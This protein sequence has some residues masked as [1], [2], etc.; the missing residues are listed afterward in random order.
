M[1]LIL[2]PY[3]EK[4]GNRQR[5]NGW[6]KSDDYDG[7]DDGKR[8]SVATQTD[9]DGTYRISHYQSR[10]QQSWSQWLSRKF[11]F[12]SERLYGTKSL[13]TDQEP[14]R[15]SPAPGIVYKQRNKVRN[16]VI[17]G[18]HGW[19]PQTRIVQTIFGELLGTSE[20]LC[21]GMM[22]SLHGMDLAKD[23]N[24]TEVALSTHG[25]SVRERVSMSLEQILNDDSYV[26]A[27]GKADKI[28]IAGHSQ[29]A[30]VSLLLL[31]ELARRRII[32]LRL[33]DCVL[34]SLAGILHGPYTTLR[35]NLVV[36]YVETEAARELFQF[37]ETS[38]VTR[39]SIEQCTHN[40][41]PV[42]DIHL[43][44][45]S[46][47]CWLLE[48]GLQLI[49]IASWLDEVVPHHSSLLW[50]FDHP[51]IQRYM[52]LSEQSLKR[53]SF[54]R[55]Y[56]I[57]PFPVQ[58]VET[59]ISRRN[60]GLVDYNILPMISISCADYFQGNLYSGNEHSKIYEDQ[61]V[62][63]HFMKVAALSQPV[64]SVAVTLYPFKPEKSS[65]NIMDDR[66]MSIPNPGG[67]AVSFMIKYLFQKLKPSAM[68]RLSNAYNEWQPSK[69]DKAGRELKYK[70]VAFSLVQNESLISRL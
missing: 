25:L 17:I 21:S 23:A 41:E 54:N 30:V 58:L 12:V 20:K 44:Y 66:Q 51:N 40:E 4:L 52:Y 33:S 34:V 15:E 70:L 61:A 35:G 14:V 45:V 63:D 69:Q 53:I 43:Q 38:L 59:L 5:L 28:I 27:L 48:S 18:I 3:D 37:C 16:L 50:S 13:T 9:F 11:D 47:L 57:E 56:Q 60:L 49:C 39:K 46:A 10:Q 68:S 24:I 62:Y 31:Y 22:N 29:G 6:G 8:S 19:F 64:R 32:D 67:Y 7:N 26:A 2:P 42:E 65:D 55:D 1:S 36:K